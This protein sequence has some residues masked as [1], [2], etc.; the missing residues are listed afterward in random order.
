MVFASNRKIADSEPTCLYSTL[1]PMISD[2]RSPALHGRASETVRSAS[3]ARMRAK[4]LSL[5]LRL[6][7]I[8]VAVHDGVP[9]VRTGGRKG[10]QHDAHLARGART[11]KGEPILDGFRKA[12]FEPRVL[13]QRLRDSLP[14]LQ[15]GQAPAPAA[16]LGLTVPFQHVHKKNFERALE[17]I[18]LLRAHVAQLLGNVF[19]VDLVEESGSQ[20]FNLFI[21]PRIEIVLIARAGLHWRA[22]GHLP[23]LSRRVHHCAL[24]LRNS[25]LSTTLSALSGNSLPNERW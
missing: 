24:P 25:Q 20:Q 18:V 9:V 2:T 22:A 3:A 6:V 11:A 17:L 1:P 21:H 5:L 19:G 15:N 23:L 10:L 7:Q 13:A 8:E 16:P 4:V 14:L 12:G